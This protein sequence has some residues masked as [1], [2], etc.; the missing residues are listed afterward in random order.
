[1]ESKKNK[2]KKEISEEEEE[3]EYEEEE[4]EEEEGKNEYSKDSFLVDEKEEEEIENDERPF[5]LNP[6]NSSI[7]KEAEIEEDLG[8]SDIEV[9]HPKVKKKKKILKKNNKVISEDEEAQIIKTEKV[10]E[11]DKNNNIKDENYFIENDR[12]IKNE[13]ENDINDEKQYIQRDYSINDVPHQIFKIPEV[14]NEELNKKTYNYYFPLVEIEEQF[15][16]SE[17]LRIKKEDFPERLQLKFKKEDMNNLGNDLDNE[18]E[19]IFEKLKLQNN[20]S[21]ENFS[22]IKKKIFTLLE[23]H[24]K[25]FLDIPYIVVYRKYIYEPE[26][27]SKDIWKLFELDKEYQEIKSYRKKVNEQFEIIEN[28]IGEETFNFMKERY[29]DGAKSIEDL[30]NMELYIKFQKE[31]NEEKIIEIKKVKKGL[32][33]EINNSQTFNYIPPIQ[34]S[35]VKK[36]VKNKLNEYSSKFALSARDFAF[37]LELILNDPDIDN[38]KLIP[39]PT[40]PSELPSQLASKYL[41]D[42][43]QQVLNVMKSVCIF[44]SHE[45]ESHPF[46]RQYI[47]QHFKNNCYLS[48]EPTELGQKDIDIFSRA[49][50]TKRLNKKPIN[51]FNNDLYLDIIQAE[52]KGLIKVKIEINIS[53]SEYDKIK[54]PLKKAYMPN[55]DENNNNDEESQWR[56]MR[57]EV[58]RIF[59]GERMQ[60]QFK[61][62]IRKELEKNAEEY[63]IEQCGNAFMD[64]LM[65][66]PYR[67]RIVDNNDDEKLF[68]DNNLPRVLSFVFNNN[69]NITYA[70]MLNKNGEVIDHFNFN[71][72]HQKYFSKTDDECKKEQNTIKNIIDQ[73][74]PDLI[75]IGANDL[76]CRYLKENINQHF[77][78]KNKFWVTYGGLLH[79]ENADISGT[80]TAESGGFGTTSEK[81]SINKTI[82]DHHYVIHHKDFWVETESTSTETGDQGKKT[83]VGIRGNIMAE[84]GQIGKTRTD[85]DGTDKDTLFLHYKWYHWHLP[86]D[87]EAFNDNT[88][89][90]DNGTGKSKDTT[91]L[92]YHP[93]FSVTRGGDVRLDGKI[94]SEEGRVGGWVIKP[95]Y[96]QSYTYDSANNTGAKLSCDGEASFGTLD[97]H[98]TGAINDS[99]KSWYITSSGEAHFTN[100]SNTYVGSSVQVGNGVWGNHELVLPEGEHFKI[101]DYADMTATAQGFIFTGNSKYVGTMTVGNNQQLQLESGS[102]IVFG[103]GMTL[104]E[105]GLL[106]PNSYGIDNNGYGNLA[107]LNIQ[108]GSYYFNNSGQ[109]KAS[110]ITI[111]SETLDAYIRRVMSEVGYVSS[112]T[113]NRSELGNL[114]TGDSVVTSVS[115]GTVGPS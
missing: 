66:G 19:W 76:K 110:S 86:A 25:K 33:N 46:L 53:D 70:V 108:N 39:T 97:L 107:S 106:F 100:P 23:Y 15:A 102:Q 91:Y 82:D 69:N 31:L 96:L 36:A 30:K 77:M 101:G 78:E 103:V 113:A 17:D 50:R 83:T 72:F 92:L 22:N 28:F 93:N 115:V 12:E 58:I 105:Y 10:Y 57:D 98:K 95:N 8:S 5:R 32:E 21:E 4:E 18:K 37:N 26:L 64:L 54:A 74:K 27:T 11:E 56:I 24:K 109:I 14:E 20:N 2:K 65:S 43:L 35:L 9:I 73:Q 85:T 71:Y 63:V 6:L 62:E 80:I 13:D 89:Y 16:T 44:L 104:S 111:G 40:N 114:G 87:N 81:V 55:S 112:V 38:S 47:W 88:Y 52:K 29:I 51:S 75:I 60:N 90:L 3:E 41:S 61:E 84:S 59:I 67:K 94:F 79:A 7:E 68:K 1:M 45:I 34:Y 42:D 49:F 48:T 99:T